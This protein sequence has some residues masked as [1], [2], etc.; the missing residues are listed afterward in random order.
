VAGVAES[1]IVVPVPVA[2]PVI[3]RWRASYDR[4]AA[5]GV[6]AHVTL[7][8][9]F[10]PPPVP[11]SVVARLRTL[12]GSVTGWRATYATFARFPG[13]VLC[14]EPSPAELFVA[15]TALL[16]GEWPQCPPYGG[17]YDTV[18]PHL[19]LCDGVPAAVADAAAADVAPLLP[20]AGD[21]REAWLMEQAVA[22]G[23]YARTA[24]LPLAPA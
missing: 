10:L 6:P 2:D 3:G 4:A 1:G 5:L 14:L 21:V 17:A 9:P 20:L 12:L 15:L 11:A 13:E 7:L 18:I 22:G 19:T 23:P 8:Y 24:V 16:A